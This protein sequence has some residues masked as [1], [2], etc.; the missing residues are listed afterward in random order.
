VLVYLR[1]LVMRLKWDSLLHKQLES[2][3]LVFMP[4]VNPGGMWRVRAP[5]REASTSC[6]MLLWKRRKGFP[7]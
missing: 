7:S 2:V 3:R 4:L 6:A 1:S 5:I